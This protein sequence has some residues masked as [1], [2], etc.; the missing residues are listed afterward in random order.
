MIRLPISAGVTVI[1]GVESEYTDAVHVVVNDASGVPLWVKRIAHRDAAQ[2]VV[3]GRTRQLLGVQ[4]FVP[5]W[6]NRT[7]VSDAALSFPEP[8]RRTPRACP[9]VLGYRPHCF[10]AATKSPL[11]QR[12][13]TP[14]TPCHCGFACSSLSHRQYFGDRRERYERCSAVAYDLREYCEQRLIRHPNATKEDHLRLIAGALSVEKRGVTGGRDSG[15][16][17]YCELARLERRMAARYRRQW[18]GRGCELDIGML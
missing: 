18:S 2:Q 12:G 6:V 17:A 16:F 11:L 4:L 3:L 5:H 7:A 1:K 13:F 10:T 8:N 14:T 9:S 15:S